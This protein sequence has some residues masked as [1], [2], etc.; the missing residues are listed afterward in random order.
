MAS[1]EPAPVWKGLA[2]VVALVGAAC[3]GA[4]LA[5][6]A[7]LFNSADASAIAAA[8]E[9]TSRRTEQQAFTEVYL[10][11]RAQAL[12]MQQGETLAGL[13]TRAGASQ[14]DASAVINSISSVYS[15]RR[16]RPGQ[17]VNLY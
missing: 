2:A 4:G 8:R 14:G 12:E 3:V 11:H 13:M 5:W 16:L 10:S 7:G 15:P 17:S 6:N 1:E 9:A